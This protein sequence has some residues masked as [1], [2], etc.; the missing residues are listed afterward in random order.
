[1]Y[2]QSMKKYILLIAAS[3]ISSMAFAQAILP[4]NVTGGTVS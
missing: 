3:L 4:D 2:Y 1:M